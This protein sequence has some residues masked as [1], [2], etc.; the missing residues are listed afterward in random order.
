M[1]FALLR[2]RIALNSPAEGVGNL[3]LRKLNYHSPHRGTA[4]I[5]KD[6]TWLSLIGV[7]RAVFQDDWVVDAEFVKLKAR[8]KSIIGQLGAMEQAMILQLEIF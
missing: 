3:Q 8:I 6:L 2:L 7:H 5:D 4:A 1:K